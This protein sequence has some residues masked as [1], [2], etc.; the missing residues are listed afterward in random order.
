MVKNPKTMIWHEIPPEIIALQ[1][2]AMEIP[3]IQRKTTWST[4]EDQIKEEM[5][6]LKHS[7]IDCVVWG[8][9]PPGY[10]ALD[11]SR[12]LG[13]YLQLKAEKDWIDRVC[14]EKKIKPIT[15]LWK[16]KPQ[17]VLAD[18]IRAGFEAIVVVVNPEVLDEEWLGRKVD[19]NFL[20]E[21]CKLHEEK[22][23]HICG[24]EYHTFVIDGPLFKKRLKIAE[25]EKIFKNGYYILHISKVELVDKE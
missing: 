4:F 18:L 6:M 22:G 21:I 15:P 8:I 3:I 24:D 23:I 10:P 14:R 7:G 2:K 9:A 19:C 16:K 5:Q 13:D 12:K 25:S 17:Q 20:Q 1:A 11:D